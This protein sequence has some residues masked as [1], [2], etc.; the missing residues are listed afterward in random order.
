MSDQATTITLVEPMVF[1]LVRNKEGKYFRAKGFGGYGDTWVSDVKS[2]K[3]YQKVGQ[4]KSRVTFFAKNYP[5][6]GV[7]DILMVTAS[8]AVLVGQ[9]ERTAKAIKKAED[10]ELARKQGQL[11]RQKAALEQQ[12]G[13]LEEER[14]RLG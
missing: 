9:E 5:E 10:A 3:V 6:Y 14:R 4:A 13:R 2:A 11:K 12:I 7:P 8:T 1:Y